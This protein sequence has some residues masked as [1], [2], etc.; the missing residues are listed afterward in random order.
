MVKHRAAVALG[1]NL[2]SAMGDRE[3]TL[4]AALERVGALGEVVGVSGFVD[5]AP[6]GVVEQPRFLNGALVLR[7]ELGAEAL[8]RELLAVERG[9]G[10]VRDGV[11]SK[12]PRTIDLDLLLYDDVVMATPELVL[13][14]PAM[15]ARRFVLEPLAEIA[16]GWRHPVLGRTVRELL[17]ALG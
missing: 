1:S 11:A 15:H 8:M 7:T 5:T 12:G 9:L 3:A 6:V 10:R 17:D 14:H 16:G 4:E 2:G 13:P